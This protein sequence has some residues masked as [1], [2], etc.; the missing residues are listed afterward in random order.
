MY[1]RGQQLH[2]LPL[3]RGEFITHQLVG[4]M[5][6]VQVV[7]FGFAPDHVDNIGEPLA[8]PDNEILQAGLLRLKVGNPLD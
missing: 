1:Q 3:Q 6:G 8:L 4:I 2:I 5:G 7:R